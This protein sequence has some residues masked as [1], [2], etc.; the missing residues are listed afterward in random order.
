[1][2]RMFAQVIRLNTQG[3]KWHHGVHITVS[4]PGLRALSCLKPGQNP[5]QASSGLGLGGL[6]ARPNTSLGST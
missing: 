3:F 6:W 2:L 4:K 5:L 1:M